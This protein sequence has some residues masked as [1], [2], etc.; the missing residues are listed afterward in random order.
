MKVMSINLKNG[1]ITPPSSNKY[2]KK[3]LN[4]VLNLL[5]EEQPDIIGTQEMVIKV[6]DELNNLFSYYNL[7]YKIYG[8][9]R[10][11][12]G[13]IADEYNAIIVKENIKV[14]DTDTYALSNTPLI[15]KSKFPL[16]V[17]PRITTSIETINFDY[18]NTHLDNLFKI[19]RELQL[20]CM[21]NLFAQYH[22][23][24]KPLIIT[25]DFNMGYNYLL[26]QFCKENNLEDITKNIGKTFR[27]NKQLPQLDHI[28]VSKDI[29]VEEI[30]KY[31]NSYNGIYPSDHYPIGAK[32]KIKK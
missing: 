25:G 4:A 11:R 8:K 18:Y 17:F 22:D 29:E 5:E 12:N 10:S 1:G 31:T 16:D 30:Y 3:R 24:N 19:N 6:K 27:E 14:L 9:S 2:W 15:P 20:T 21:T 13:S 32:I 23:Q 28:L 7:P 26:D